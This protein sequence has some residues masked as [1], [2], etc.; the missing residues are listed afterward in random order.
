M[1][2]FLT[3]T[4]LP[5]C[6]MTGVELVLNKYFSEMISWSVGTPSYYIIEFANHIICEDIK[7]KSG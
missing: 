1:T 3:I 7:F 4:Y 5:P 6:L 2:I